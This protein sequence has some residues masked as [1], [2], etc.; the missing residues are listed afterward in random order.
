MKAIFVVVAV[1]LFGF[2]N[3]ALAQLAPGKIALLSLVGDSLEIVTYQ[4]N[5]GSNIDRNIRTKVSTVNPGLDYAALLAA[6][7][8]LKKVLPSVATVLLAVPAADSPFDP[9]KLIVDG[10][11]SKSSGLTAMLG[12]ESITHLL[13]ITKHRAPARL[14]MVD[15]TIGNGYLEGLGFY[16]DRELETQRTDTGDIGLGFVAGYAYLKMTLVN[17]ETLQ[18]QATEVID[19][20]NAQSAARNK[21]GV[22]PWGALSSTEKLS[23]MRALIERG[24]SDATT[25]IIRK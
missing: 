12:K 6:N 19:E 21:T 16:I 17:V 9:S 1:A 25:R 14:R 20:S 22:D 15:S 10:K 4:S 2:S 8:A 3:T 11:L 13:L 18:V 5:T 7:A 23:L 24:V